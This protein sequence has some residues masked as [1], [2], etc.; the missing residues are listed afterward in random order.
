MEP[1][2]YKMY[3]QFLLLNLRDFFKLMNPYN[4]SLFTRLEI[5]LGVSIYCLFAY[6]VNYQQIIF[7][8]LFLLIKINWHMTVNLFE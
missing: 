3:R 2:N 6:I 5:L 4:T 8:E 1:Y 7:K